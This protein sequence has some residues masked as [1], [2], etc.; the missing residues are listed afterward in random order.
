MVNHRSD[1]DTKTGIRIDFTI[2]LTT[3][4]SCKL[5]PEPIRMVVYYDKGTGN[6]VTFII[7]DFEI[8]ALEIA[9]L[10]RYCWNIEVFFK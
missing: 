9:N 4:K 7:N 8:S 2:R 6:E 5:Y 1:F 3:P 10:D